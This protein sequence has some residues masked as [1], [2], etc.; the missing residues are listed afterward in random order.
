MKK[1]VN[2]ILVLAVLIGLSGIAFAEGGKNQKQSEKGKQGNG[3]CVRAQDCAQDGSGVCENTGEKLMERKQLRDGSGQGQF[4]NQDGAGRKG[5]GG[6]K[7]LNGH[8]GNKG[9]N[10]HGR[11]K[12]LRDGS[13]QDDLPPVETEITDGYEEQALKQNKKGSG[14]RQRLQDESC[15]ALAKGAKKGSGDRQRLQ[16]ETCLAQA[17]R[18]KKGSGSGDRQR[19]QDGSCAA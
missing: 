11:N 3:E 9:L 10:G 7:G 8:G 2:L 14:D 19:L 6:N 18:A 1:I 12:R 15:L 16:D 5:H 13:C 4:M 17:N